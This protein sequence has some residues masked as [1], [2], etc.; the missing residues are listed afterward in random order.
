VVGL[1]MRKRVLVYTIFLLLLINLPIFTE[2]DDL[3]KTIFKTSKQNNNNKESGFKDNKM[4]EIS[5]KKN[6]IQKLSSSVSTINNYESENFSI[7]SKWWGRDIEIIKGITGEKDLVIIWTSRKYFH[8]D[9]II[10]F[11]IS[12]PTE[13]VQEY[14]WVSEYPIFDIEL[15]NYFLYIVQGDFGIKIIDIRNP[16]NPTE[17]TTYDDDPTWD[18]NRGYWDIFCS[19]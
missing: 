5:E 4:R 11:N 15:S 16:K 10:I 18:E 9:Y 13:P 3:K 6:E 1:K 19:I 7:A 12:N 2:N 17:I 14:K 8:I